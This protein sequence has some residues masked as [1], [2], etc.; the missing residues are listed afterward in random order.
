MQG[1]KYAGKIYSSLK[2]SQTGT[3]GFRYMSK[4]ELN[5]IQKGPGAGY[6]RGGAEGETFFTKNIYTSASK[7]KTRLSLKT[8]P[9]LRVEFEILNNPTLLRNGTKVRPNYGEI[10]GGAE[11]MTQDAVKVKLI[12]WQP[13]LKSGTQ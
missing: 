2:T 12:N 11:F 9:E 10:G 6:L 13:L 3:I 7:A 1:F 8:A 5:A 4:G